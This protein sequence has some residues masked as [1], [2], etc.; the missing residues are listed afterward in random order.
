MNESKLGVI[1]YFHTGE[2]ELRLMP[3]SVSKERLLEEIYKF[4]RDIEITLQGDVYSMSE[5]SASDVA[6]IQFSVDEGTK[7]IKSID[8][9]AIGNS[10][11]SCSITSGNGND[12]CSVTCPPATHPRR[13]TAVCR[14]THD[15]ASCYCE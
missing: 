10:R 4:P 11:G 13:T 1:T 6:F 14:R 7:V 3:L 9:Q 15:S 12:R 8:V 5:I 2:E